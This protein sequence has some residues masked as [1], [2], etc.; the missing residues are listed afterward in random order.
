MRQLGG[1]AGVWI[2]EQLPELRELV[3]DHQVG[4]EGVHAGLR[5]GVAQLTDEGSDPLPPHAL[6]RDTFA[7]EGPHPAQDGRAVFV[8]SRV[9]ADQLL[10]GLLNC[11]IDL[12]SE[13]LTEAFSGGLSMRWASTVPGALSRVWSRNY[14]AAEQ[15]GKHTAGASGPWTPA[16][17]KARTSRI[18]ELQGDSALGL[19]ESRSLLRQRISDH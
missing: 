18:S 6:P 8:C 4:L 9:G 10:E 12:A 11:R 19:A 17:T 1:L 2:G 13:P 5:Q 15:E 3:K 16:T 14:P 7:D